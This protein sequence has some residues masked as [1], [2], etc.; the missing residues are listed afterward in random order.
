[1]ARFYKSHAQFYWAHDDE[2][3]ECF[4][5]TIEMLPLD[6]K[7]SIDQKEHAYTDRD[8][9]GRITGTGTEDFNPVRFHLQTRAAWVWTWDGV[10]RNRGG[11]RRFECRGVIVYRASDAREVRE[12]YK[13]L[14]GAALVQ[15]R[16]V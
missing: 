8:A 6:R 13:N 10:S 5:G 14:T 9:S 16:T 15:L 7:L 1:M 11:H 12:M 2:T 4:A 3:G